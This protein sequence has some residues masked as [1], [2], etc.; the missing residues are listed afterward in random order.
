MK[1]YRLHFVRHG[2]TPGNAKGQ[3][4]GSRTDSELSPEGIRELIDL[5][6]CYE[7]PAVG[8][9]YASPMTRCVQT[10]GIL[11]GERPLTMVPQLREVDFGAF[12]GKTIG[13]LQDNPAYTAWLANSMAVSPP[14]GENGD[15]F[16][17]RTVEGLRFI[18]DDMMKN[19]IYDGAVVT[20][21]GVIMTLLAALGLP[22]RPMHQW[23]VGNG[24]G[25][26]CFVTPELWLR[27]GV[28]EVAGIMPH[29]AD[30]TFRNDFDEN[31]IP[32]RTTGTDY[33]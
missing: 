29:G 28:L 19:E 17:A 26:T 5:R 22:Q 8:M 9:V 10:V 1:N 6:E 21:G 33:E 20:H 2:M 3:Y 16:L 23:M 32:G 25:Y 4:I 24:R 30:S 12:E 31:G 15:A 27:D 11:Y 7:Y 14:E 13:E 18:L